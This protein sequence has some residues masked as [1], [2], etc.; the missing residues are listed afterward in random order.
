[1]RAVQSHMGRHQFRAPGDTSR[2]D[3]AW[4]WEG[5]ADELRRGQS[6]AGVTGYPYGAQVEIRGQAEPD[7]R[8][9]GVLPGGA[10]KVVRV[11]YSPGQGQEVPLARPAPHV[12]LQ[13]SSARG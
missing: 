4:R 8:D 5:S 7:S 9:R 6:H 10:Q 12:L 2:P 11:S 3:E 1:G 13:V